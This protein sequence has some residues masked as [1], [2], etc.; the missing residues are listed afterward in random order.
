MSGDE[1]GVV[2]GVRGQERGLI[3]SQRRYSNQPL[4]VLDQRGAVLADRGHR[5]APPHSE[6]GGDLRD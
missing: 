4:G 5:G 1:H 2:G 6:V 3:H